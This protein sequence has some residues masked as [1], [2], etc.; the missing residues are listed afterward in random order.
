MSF[1]APKY[2]PTSDHEYK[3]CGGTPILKVIAQSA[4]Q[5]LTI[6]WGDIPPNCNLNYLVNIENCVWPQS[7]VQTWIHPTCWVCQVKSNTQH[8][9][10]RRPHGLLIKN[11]LIIFVHFFFNSILRSSGILM[12]LQFMR[13]CLKISLKYLIWLM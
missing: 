6:F 3:P 2:G 13:K 12:V 8:G 4:S 10:H 11:H 1:V 9:I 5:Y 7:N